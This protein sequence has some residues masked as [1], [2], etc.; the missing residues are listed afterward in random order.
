MNIIIILDNIFI[1][2]LN[3][4]EYIAINIIINIVEK[5]HI[6]YILVNLKAKDDFIL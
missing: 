3:K 2:N 4:Y 6:L 5:W 1:K